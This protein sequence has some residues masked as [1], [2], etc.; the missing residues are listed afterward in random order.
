MCLVSK[1]QK[2]IFLCI[3]GHTIKPGTPEL[4]IMEQGTLVEHWQNTETLV[5]NQNTGKTIRILQNTGT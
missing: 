4:R 2:C 3:F 5:E 1:L